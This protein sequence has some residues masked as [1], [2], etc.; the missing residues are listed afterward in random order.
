MT[1]DTL[2]AERLALLVDAPAAPDWGDV[3]RRVRRARRRRT[4]TTTLVVVAA[5]V[6]AAPVAFGLRRHVVD[7]LSADPAPDRVQLTFAHLEVGAPKGMAPGVIAGQTRKVPV[8]SLDGGETFVWVAPTRRGGFCLT[9]QHGAGGCH[10]RTGGGVGASFSGSGDENG[11][12]IRQ[13][14]GATTRTEAERLELR[15]ADG[16]KLELP[17]TWVS[18]PIDAGF[19]AYEIPT[20]RRPAEL[21]LYADGDDVVA[22]ESFPNPDPL[23]TEDPA[24]G[25]PKAVVYAE[26]REVLTIETEGGRQITLYSAPSRLHTRGWDGRC[27]WLSARGGPVDRAFYGC[28]NPAPETP[29]IA[30][31]IHGGGKPVLFAGAVAST[32]HRSSCASRTAT[33]SSCPP[34]R[35]TCWASSQLGTTRLAIDS[36]SQWPETRQASKSEERSSSQR[37]GRSTGARA[38]TRS[39]S[40][41]ASG[42][43][44]EESQHLGVGHANSL[45]GTVQRSGCRGYHA[46][47][48]CHDR[49]ARGCSDCEREDEAVRGRGGR[50][51]V[52]GRPRRPD[53]SPALL[54]GGDPLAAGGRARLL[55]CGGGH[56]PRARLRPSG[57]AGP[58]PC[59]RATANGDD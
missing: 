37:P 9:W 8:R 29:P 45:D 22:R 15:F 19:Y 27:L 35:G 56:P 18:P 12:T 43:A 42:H 34:R 16:T 33:S 20:G 59:R 17:I 28:A 32:S 13:V 4:L 30:A 7:F 54:P 25:L 3:T 24:T 53:L 46:A 47:R 55:E 39:T 57:R 5:V 31:G 40:G 14:T 51:L 21:V 10:A 1:D 26:R 6:V 36:T 38:R 52:R 23:V 50:R 48:A 49:G 11:V 44:R 58:W 2:L 41:S